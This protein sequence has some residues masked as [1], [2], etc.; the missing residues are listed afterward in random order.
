M[1]TPAPGVYASSQVVTVR[2]ATPSIRVQY[3]F[4]DPSGAQGPWIALRGPIELSAA[5][6]EARDYR[7]SVRNDPAGDV[8]GDVQELS[9]RI[10]RR[11]PTAPRISPAPGAYW[12]P[13]S[14]HFEAAAGDSVYYSVQ[15]DV[16]RSPVAWD[17]KDVVVGA[18][19]ARS[20]LVVQAYTVTPAGGHSRI[21]TS[22]YLVDT[23][24]PTVEI[25]SPVEGTFANPQ[26]LAL[27][28]RNLQWVRYTLDGSDPAAGGTPYAG[29]VTLDR[30]GVVTVKIAGMPRAQHR[31]VIRAEVKYTCTA[32]PGPQ[33]RLDTENGTYPDGVTPSVVSSPG[34]TLYYTLWERTPRDSD[35][36]AT[37]PIAINSLAAG[38]TPVALRLRALSDSGTWSAEYRYFYFVGRGAPS[39]PIIRVDPSDVGPPVAGQPGGASRVQVLAPEDAVFSATA[40]GGMPDPKKPSLSSWIELGTSPGS[41][42]A[43]SAGDGSD[44]AGS[45]PAGSKVPGAP[46]STS[47]IQAVAMDGAGEL[48]P[49]AQMRV[50]RDAG[51]AS[52]PGF[53]FAAGPVRGTAVLGPAGS[54]G[55]RVVY[56]LTSDGSDPAV[57]GQDSPELSAAVVLSVPYGTSRTFKA[58]VAVIDSAGGVGS[59]SDVVS[60]L[61]DRTPPPPPRL[62]PA[63]GILDEP[64]VVSLESSAK[65]YFSLTSDGSMPPD[66]G[67]SSPSNTFAALP[68]VDGRTVTYRLK[69][70]AVDDAGNASEVYGPLAYTV[71]LSPPTIPPITGIADGGHYAARQVSPVIEGGHAVSIRYTAGSDGSEPPEP[72]A[73]SPELTNATVFRCEVGAVT[74]WT[75]KLLAVSHNGRRQGEKKTLTFYMSQRPPSVPALGG[76]PPEGRVAHP[77]TLSPGQT[78]AGTRVVYSISDDGSEP[79]DPLLSG[80]P[81]PAS[82]TLDAP[83]GTRKDYTLRVAA[84]DAAGNTSLS[85]RRYR[86]AVDR[87][88]PVDPVVRGA[89]EGSI[90]AATVTLSL[91]SEAASVVFELT[92]DGSMPRVP[93]AASRAYSGPFQLVGKEGAAVTYRLIA[94]A[95]NDLGTAS[96]AARLFRVTIDRTV[97][98]SPA[99]P[100]L[101]FSDANPGVA[102][103]QW[104]VPGTGRVLYRLDSPAGAAETSGGDFLPAVG[105]VSV[106]VDPGQG[107]VIRGTAVTENAAGTRS[108]PAGFSLPVGSRLP[109]PVFRG[110]RDGVPSAQGIQ[111]SCT[112]LQGEVR[113]EIS[114][115]GGFTPTVTSASPRFPPQ[116]ALDAAEGQTVDATI[117]AR[118]FDPAGKAIPS[119]EVTLHAIVDRTPPDAPTASG[120][121]DGGHYQDSRKV[122][123]LSSEG[124]IYDTVTIGTD[125]VVPAQTASNRYVSPLVLDAPAGAS[126]T[127]RM[128]AFSVDAAGNRSR[129]VRSWTVTIDRMIVYASPNGSDF[130]DGSRDTPVRSIRRAAQ[131]A[132]TGSRRTIYAAAGSYPE[133]SPV[134]IAGD[135]AMVG[136]LDP[137][138]WQPLRLERW[139]TISESERWKG[140]DALVEMTAGSASIR[141]FDLDGGPSSAAPLLAVTGG[142]VL[143]AGGA[144]TLSGP[145][146]G[147]AILQTGGDLSLQDLRLQAQGGWQGSFLAASGG[148]LD[149]SG[150]RFS[151]PTGSP[152]FVALDL[153]NQSRAMIKG[154]TVDP[155]SGLKTRAIRAVSTAVAITASRITSGTGSLEA[156]GLDCNASTV[157]VDTTD[158]SAAAAARFPAAAVASGGSLRITGSRVAV[159]GAGSAVGLNA[160]GADVVLL[161]SVLR[162]APTPERLALV[163]LEDSRAL[164]AND[165]LVGAPAGESIGMQVRGGATDVLNNTIVGGEGASI[166]TAILVQGDALPRLVNNLV[167]RTG[168]ERGSAITVL[169]ARGLFSTA[170]GQRAVVLSNV[171]GGWKELAHVEYGRESAPRDLADVDAL[172][173]IDGTPYGGSVSGNLTE[174]P[175]ASF[176]PDA[177]DSYRLVRGSACLDAGVDLAAPQGPAGSEPLLLVKPSE[178]S[179]DLLG[180]S[181]PGLLPLAVRGPP[182]GWDIGAYEYTE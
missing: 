147:P 118:V 152:D 99:A 54:A 68:G 70:I 176:G 77:V 94:R 60:V 95:F 119:R 27:T 139:S 148:T 34:G 115:D 135:L 175:R 73:R 78:P 114:T 84:V 177:G 116:L 1:V 14:V 181:R 71:D 170:P 151:G 131:V 88:V 8:A 150:C 100:V 130:S 128:T 63:P 98:A 169:D 53:R 57:P 141:G 168:A 149:I 158:L 91:D 120:I 40:D 155:G 17:G 61:V 146:A 79:A 123:L 62:N 160:H 41:A 7:L 112:A 65:V 108:V 26:A 162:A 12:D 166:T 76:F 38:P 154:S 69:V 129:E 102:Y 106:Q 18:A 67:L 110:A 56:S 6:G 124:T 24:A 4:R 111:L 173:R 90:S 133:E 42:G 30:R 89:A 16:V 15:G 86:L 51:S 29:P 83:D 178:V 2:P 25:M 171:F 101:L 180:N 172:D 28:F 82:L 39:A 153:K 35:A 58:R 74:Q 55:G 3:S 5:P 174:P 37:S 36:L 126:V 81:F 142:S 87:E 132:L 140:G 23:R 157:S 52:V 66:P 21:V 122:D 20:D 134:Q 10:D 31:G 165:L 32:P 13:V 64:A 80:A 113:Y 59:V 103:L 104:P 109:P 163:R 105:P 138:T 50:A 161:R 46:S 48:S 43:A 164:I 125:V 136:G 156:I 49:V 11:P 97:P 22:R 144:V 137:Q 127:Y 47:V 92:D 117:A 145:G 19:D 45:T 72:D 93:S 9:Y 75:V 96:P 167:S 121:E 85:D 107:S 44:A 159:A 179:P 143:L 182:R 33:L